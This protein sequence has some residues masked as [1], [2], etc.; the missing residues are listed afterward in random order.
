MILE[1]IDSLGGAP[2][3]SHQAIDIGTKHC[4]CVIDGK[5]RI[6]SVA[7]ELTLPC[8]RRPLTLKLVVGCQGKMSFDERWIVL[9]LI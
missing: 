7:F 4:T 3:L 9:V 6:P 2:C 5:K 8:H 1:P